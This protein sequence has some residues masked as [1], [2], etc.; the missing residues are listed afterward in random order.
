[1]K[2]LKVHC[3]TALYTRH[4]I[5]LVKNGVYGRIL[6]EKKALNWLEDIWSWIQGSPGKQPVEGT[7]DIEFKCTVKRKMVTVTLCHLWLSSNS[8]GK[9]GWVEI[10]QI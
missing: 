3:V 4:T 2:S 10:S 1:M 9:K 5:C 7:G 6:C 8:N